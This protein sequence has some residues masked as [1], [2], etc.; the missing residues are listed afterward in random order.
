MHRH[1]EEIETEGMLI[2]W[3]G[4]YDILLTVATLGRER[5]FRQRI[6]DAASL[7]EGSRVLDVGC[8]TGTLAMAAA[9]TMNNTGSVN[10]VDAAPEMIERAR[11]KGKNAGLS[12]S[13]N[14][15]V[16]EK[17]DFPDESMDTVFSTL[18]LHHLPARLQ[19]EGLKEIRRV[20]APLG[21]LVLADFGK[22]HVAENKL[23]EAGFVRVERRPISPGVLFMLVAYKADAA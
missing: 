9:K 4:F 11:T 15:G 12:I 3:A 19:A 18:M 23:K 14:I 8:G 5:R 20:L 1:T 2:R 17:L 10:G 6:V 16:I 13:F 22:A 7:A 21:R